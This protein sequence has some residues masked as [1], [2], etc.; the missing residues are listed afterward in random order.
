M[1]TQVLAQYIEAVSN[2]LK[3]RNRQK[4]DFFTKDEQAALKWYGQAS[5]QIE[6]LKVEPTG[7]GFVMRTAAELAPVRLGFGAPVVKK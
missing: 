3:R 4:R 6:A 7:E 2:Q 1:F 5:Q